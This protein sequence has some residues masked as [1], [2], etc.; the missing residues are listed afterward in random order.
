MGFSRR[1]Q[2]SV[3]PSSPNNNGAQMAIPANIKTEAQAA[4][5]SSDPAIQK[6]G[7]TLVELCGYVEG[8]E[9]KADKAMQEA[10]YAT[11]EAKKQAHR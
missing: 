11:N 7:S 1:V 2:V 5:A 3:T 10:K 9:S 8:I 6:L 4:A